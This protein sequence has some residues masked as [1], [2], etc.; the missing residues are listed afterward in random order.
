MPSQ[1]ILWM[2]SITPI[3]ISLFFISLISFVGAFTLYLN[4]KKLRSVLVT[5]T[6]FAAGALLAVT[7][8]DLMPEAVEALDDNAPSCSAQSAKNEC[9]ARDPDG[10]DTNQDNLDFIKAECTFGESNS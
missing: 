1:L 4:R 8:F 2:N 10:Q 6:S 9:L 7:F 5:L 3:L